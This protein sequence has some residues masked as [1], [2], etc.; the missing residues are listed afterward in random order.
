MIRVHPQLLEA[1]VVALSAVSGKYNGEDRAAVA[2]CSK[3]L[4]EV[5]TTSP[6]N[7]VRISADLMDDIERFLSMHDNPHVW[8]W[9]AVELHLARERS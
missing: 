3:I 2:C 8:G 7:D 9:L 5:W 6:D 1:A 4:K